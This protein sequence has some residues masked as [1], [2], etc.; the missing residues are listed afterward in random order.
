VNYEEKGHTQAQNVSRSFNDI[1]RSISAFK[2][3]CAHYND[4]AL[5]IMERVTTEL[6]TEVRGLTESIQE[7]AKN[8]SHLKPIWKATKTL[9]KQQVMVVV[10]DSLRWA[11]KERELKERELRIRYHDSQDATRLDLELKSQTNLLQNDMR[12]FIKIWD[13]IENDICIITQQLNT[14][15]VNCGLPQHFYRRLLFLPGQYAALMEALDLYV[16]ALSSP[17]NVE[18][19]TIEW[20]PQRLKTFAKACKVG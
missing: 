10:G 7:V 17:K 9:E 20:F 2:R 16:A 14:I 3:K 4:G 15:T 1:S 11:E 18:L 6:E 19:H 5:L 8:M 12:G 13:M